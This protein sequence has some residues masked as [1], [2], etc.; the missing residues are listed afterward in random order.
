M[1]TY[2]Q[3][4]LF[5]CNLVDNGAFFPNFKQ[6]N[7][8]IKTISCDLDFYNSRTEL[9]IGFYLSALL[10]LSSK[11]AWFPFFITRYSITLVSPF[12]AQ[13]DYFIL[14][15]R[16]ARSQGNETIEHQE[17]VHCTLHSPVNTSYPE[18]SKN[19]KSFDSIEMAHS[20]NNYVSQ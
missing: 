9:F 4:Y 16:R 12:L 10:A 18:L 2:H 17:V 13:F 5:F 19:N 11:L 1:K 3:I 15:L 6:H 20:P 8:R 7:Q 14:Y